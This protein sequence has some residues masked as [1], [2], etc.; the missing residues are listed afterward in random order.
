MSDVEICLKKN[1]AEKE[2]GG[3][4]EEVVILY[5][6]VTDSLTEYCRHRVHVLGW[7]CAWHVGG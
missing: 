1:K 4:R 2:Y 5:M 6:V 3:V 7:D